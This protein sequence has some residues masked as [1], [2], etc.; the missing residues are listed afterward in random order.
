[1]AV[2]QIVIK[3][4][5]VFMASMGQ[6]VKMAAIALVIATVLGIVFG[7]FAVSGSKLLRSIT[8]VYVD[9]IRGTPLLVQTF[10]IYYGIAQ[11]LRPYGFAWANIGGPFTAGIVAL[12]LNAGAYMSEIMRGGIEAVDKGQV[13]AARSLGL[14]YGIC[15]RKVILPQAFRVMLPSIINQFIISLKDT[16]LI[17]VIGIRE[18]TKNGQILAANSASLVMPIWIAVALFYLIVC[19]A[20]SKTA[21]FAER[22]LAYGSKQNYRQKSKKVVWGVGGA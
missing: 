5:A 19:T 17:S 10:I 6:T 3:Y 2:V 13:E 4:A 15:M 7:L 1:M 21:R 20:L 22:R 11:T 16:S 14:P 12:S 9:L 18:L 8:A